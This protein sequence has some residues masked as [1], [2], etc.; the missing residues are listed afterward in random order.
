[1]LRLP[2]TDHRTGPRMARHQYGAAL[3]ALDRFA[4]WYA[5]IGFRIDP[6][7]RALLFLA[8]RRSSGRSTNMT[9]LGAILRTTRKYTRKL[10][11]EYA[12]RGWLS[13]T[14]SDQDNRVTLVSLTAAGWAA[15]LSLVDAFVDVADDL[16]ELSRNAR[17]QR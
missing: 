15:A 12:A 13:E 10:V 6:H 5:D 8:L 2:S 16:G 9:E 7:A 1:M 4:E 17:N 3:K 14:V 11:D